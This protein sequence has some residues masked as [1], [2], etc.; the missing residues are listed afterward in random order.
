MCHARFHGMSDCP[1][2]TEREKLEKAIARLE[3]RKWCPD[4]M[5]ALDAAK[6]H[7]ATLPKSDVWILFSDHSRTEHRSYAAVVEA[8]KNALDC[9]SSAVHLTRKPV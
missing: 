6:K 3:M 8:A 1:L 4:A 5:L 2:E 9:G 7:L